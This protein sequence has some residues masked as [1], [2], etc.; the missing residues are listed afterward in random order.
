MGVLNF[1]LSYKQRHKYLCS[2]LSFQGFLYAEQLSMIELVY[3]S[4]AK[5]ECLSLGQNAGELMAKH[6]KHTMYPLCVYMHTHDVS[7]LLPVTKVS[8]SMC[9]EFLFCNGT[10]CLCKPYKVPFSSWKLGLENHINPDPL[11]TVVVRSDNTFFP[12]LTQGSCVF[13]QNP[14][15]AQLVSLQ[16]K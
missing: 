15:Q 5:G 9:L 8:S 16:V 11:T 2:K 3:P 10:H 13:Y 12:S 6:H 4:G 1:C 7:E 14:W